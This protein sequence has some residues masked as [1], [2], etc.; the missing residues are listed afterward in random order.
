MSCFFTK[1]IQYKKTT[2]LAFYNHF[3]EI[4]AQRQILKNPK[5]PRLYTHDP[6]Q[7]TC[8][9]YDHG[10]N[11]VNIRKNAQKRTNNTVLLYRITLGNNV[12]HMGIIYNGPA[13]FRP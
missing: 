5:F 9:K 1:S 8:I 4:H 7:S 3:G 6:I 12:N 2:D 11:K 13:I 10:K